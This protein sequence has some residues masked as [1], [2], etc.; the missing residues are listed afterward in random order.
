MSN[1]TKIAE[2]LAFVGLTGSG[3]TVA[4]DYLAE[5]GYPKVNFDG[6]ISDDNLKSNEKLIIYQLFLSKF[7]NQKRNDSSN[8]RNGI[9]GRTF[10]VAFIAGERKSSG[11]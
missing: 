11:D 9:S 1:N 10:I 4:V 6:F 7:Q 8:R 5:K 2:I 3:K